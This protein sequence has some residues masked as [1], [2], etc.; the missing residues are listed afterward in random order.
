MPNDS[1]R[2]GRPT[3]Q[4]GAGVPGGSPPC[5]ALP[6]CPC[7]CVQHMAGGPWPC[8][9]RMVSVLVELLVGVP[10]VR[11]HHPQL[12]LGDALSV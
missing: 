8:S 6:R 12:V 10:R 11:G 9:P 7:A 3:R 5:P 1:R 2:G 4:W